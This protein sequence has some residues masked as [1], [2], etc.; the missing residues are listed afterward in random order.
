MDYRRLGPLVPI[1]SRSPLPETPRCAPF[2]K[3]TVSFFVDLGFS[4][5]LPI[6][7]LKPRSQQDGPYVKTREATESALFSYSM[8]ARISMLTKWGLALRTGINYSQVNEKFDFTQKS[9][10]TI[11]IT[12]IY[13]ADG[14]II[15]T[16]TVVTHTPQRTVT[17]NRYR[18]L[19]VP[20][21]LGYEKQFRRWRVGANAG[22]YFNILFAPQGEFLSPEMEPVSFTPGDPESFQAFRNRIGVGLY[23]SCQVSYHLTPRLQLLVEPHFK[24]YPETATIAE[25]EAEQNF[26]NAGLFLALRHQL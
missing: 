21:L 14:G 10:E 5:D 20:V 4:P 26:A 18:M 24:Y 8:G 6:T 22:A 23:G 7:R 2:G 11:T 1:S 3:G 15:G 12:T 9:D 19:D 13:D 17:S 16:D 25:Y